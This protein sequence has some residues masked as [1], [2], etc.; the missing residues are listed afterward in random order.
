MPICGLH[1]K[2]LPEEIAFY[3][4]ATHRELT[5]PLTVGSVG[6]CNSFH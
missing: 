5:E 3:A 4:V 6:K 2:Y 1:G